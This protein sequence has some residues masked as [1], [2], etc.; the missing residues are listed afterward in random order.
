M[1]LFS[2][3]QQVPIEIQAELHKGEHLLAWANH[4]SGMIAVTDQR[5]LD[6]GQE[7]SS[8]AWEY[9]LSA[10]WSEP[11][12]HIVFMN[13]TQ[14]LSPQT[15]KLTE[16]GLVPTAVRDRVTSVVMIDKLVDVSG[17]GRVRFV[18]HRTSGGIK[19]STFADESVDVGS[20]EHQQQIQAVLQQLRANLGV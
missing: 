15:W 5:L 2:R 11:E 20:S 9:A 14:K 3:G 12:L 16:P 4:A 10:Q 13:E 19:W 17:L 7:V 8:M 6:V 1:K 18:A